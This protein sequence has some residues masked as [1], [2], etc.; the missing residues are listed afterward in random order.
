MTGEY[1]TPWVRP[2]VREIAAAA[3]DSGQVTVQQGGMNMRSIGTVVAVIAL[4]L[5]AAGCSRSPLLSLEPL[6]RCVAIAPDGLST[7]EISAEIALDRTD[8]LFLVDNSS[9]MAHEIDRIREQ[10]AELLVPQIAEHVGD[11]QL[12]LAVFSDFGERRLGERSH[13]YQLLQPIT[14]DIDRVV[15]ATE[16]IELEYGGDNPETQLEALYQAA[17][18]DGLGVY[19]D[20]GPDCPA[21]TR[22]GVCFREGSFAIVMLFTDAPMRNVIGIEESGEE[23]AAEVLGEIKDEPFIP[24]LRGYDETLE[25]LQAETIRVVGLWSGQV[26]GLDDMRRV[27]RDTGALDE[28]GRPIVFEIGTRG[29]QLG[30]GVIGALELTT[31]GVRQD[32]RLELTDAD[33]DDG[34][35]P[36]ELV[37]SVRAVSVDP[38]DGGT[39]R[40][41]RFVDVRPGTRVR[42]AVTFDSSSLPVAAFEQRYPL[43]LSAVA[44]DGTLLS[45]ETVDVVVAAESCE[46]APT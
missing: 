4:G 9:S 17:T 21:G 30:E 35:D 42:F 27:A 32:I 8:I 18:G 22:A 36:R 10:L 1:R 40:G 14:A 26:D 44:D 28:S 7:H 16:R 20:E 11:A 24:Y 46:L 41:D 31:E 13:P 45:E 3:N 43:G 19:V 37:T 39:A 38:A 33:P 5:A 25:A 2:T 12:G 6:N 15:A 34:V 29:E 23:S